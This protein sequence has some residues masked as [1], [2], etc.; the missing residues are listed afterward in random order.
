MERFFTNKITVMFSISQSW[1]A[2]IESNFSGIPY[3]IYYSFIIQ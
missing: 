3:C 2:Y 1:F